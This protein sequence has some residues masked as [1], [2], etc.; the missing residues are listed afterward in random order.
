MTIWALKRMFKHSKGYKAL[1]PE[2]L[3]DGLASS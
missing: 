1:F 2:G 3:L